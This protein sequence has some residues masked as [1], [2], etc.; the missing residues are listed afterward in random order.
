[1]LVYQSVRPLNGCKLP[2]GTVHGG[3]QARWTLRHNT[4]R[5]QQHTKTEAA[6][7]PHSPAAIKT[8]T[9]EG[10]L[11]VATADP[12]HRLNMPGVLPI[13][14]RSAA[15]RMQQTEWP[16]TAVQRM[17]NNAWGGCPHQ[18]Q[19]YAVVSITQSSHDW[20]L[21]S[22]LLNDV[23]RWH[24]HGSTFQWRVAA[25]RGVRPAIPVLEVLHVGL[26]VHTPKQRG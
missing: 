6:E 3:P 26:Q 7:M 18:L 2:D 5:S 12:C 22:V 24:E 19:L 11:L 14:P 25:V 17:L 13:G 23:I 15:A 21:R 20:A 10:V 8:T 1:M 16:R 4:E 9:S